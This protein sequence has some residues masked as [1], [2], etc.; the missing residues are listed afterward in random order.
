MLNIEETELTTLDYILLKQQID[1][2]YVSLE[3]MLCKPC[4]RMI[5]CC[6]NLGRLYFSLFQS[7][8]RFKAMELFLRHLVEKLDANDR[9]WRQ[10]TIIVFG[11]N[12]YLT[13]S[14]FIDL[15]KQLH[16]PVC[17]TGPYTY[18]ATP[19]HLMLSHFKNADI[20]PP[21]LSAEKT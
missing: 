11:H 20:N 16:L 19:T 10:S 14:C 18:D 17:F 21:I 5:V 9:Y 12:H 15:F 13:G 8:K 3:Q 7:C 2:K 4:I 6:D 1:D